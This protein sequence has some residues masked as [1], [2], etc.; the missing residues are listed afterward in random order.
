M[1]LGDRLRKLRTRKKMRQVD[2]ARNIGVARTTYAMYE[3]NSREPDNDTLQK[4][5]DFFGVSVDYLLGRDSAPKK[6]L[7]EDL[8]E[9]EREIMEQL[10]KIA[11]EH[12][13][14]L[15][16]PVF[17]KTFEAA[18]EFAKRIRGSETEEQ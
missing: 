15:T 17:L 11:N 12:G 6:A 13:Y 2:V 10:R 8:D 4:L 1:L 16:D 9:E 5:A 18:L 3:Q 14:E 7:Y